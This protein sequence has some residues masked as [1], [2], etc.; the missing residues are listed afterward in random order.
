MGKS[1]SQVTIFFPDKILIWFYLTLAFSPDKVVILKIFPKFTEKC[2][3]DRLLSL[4]LYL[5]LKTQ[6]V[7]CFQHIFLEY[8]RMTILNKFRGPLNEIF[9]GPSRPDPIRRE[10]INLSLYFHMSLRCL[11]KVLWRTLRPS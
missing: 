6:H 11:K 10:K 2:Q 3:V 8:F 4:D 1:F 5:Y 9:L 7:R